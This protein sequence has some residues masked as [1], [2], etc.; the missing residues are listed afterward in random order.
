MKA[1]NGW[2]RNEPAAANRHVRDRF[3][4]Y[5]VTLKRLPILSCVASLL[6]FAL[7]LEAQSNVVIS[8]IYGGGGNSG[9]TLRNDFVELFN[10][11][12][13][14]ANIAG[15]SVQYASASGSNWDRAVLSGAVQ[16]GQYYLVQL[17]QGTGGSAGLPAPD[18]T[19]GLNLSAT[20][21]KVA[22]V[23]NSTLLT[24]T[25]P[26]GSQVVD[27]VGY[28]EANFA[29][30]GRS[31]P[32]LSN[33]TAG[34]RRSGGCTDSNNNQADF[35][36]GQPAPRNTRSPLAPCF[37]TT[38][39]QI[40]AA[41]VTNGATFRSGPVAPGEIITLFGSGLGP[42][43]ISTLQLTSDRLFVTKSLAGTRV[44]FDGA[45]AA[46][47]YTAAAQVSAITPYSLSGQ[48]STDLQVEYEG[49]LSN[50]VTLQVAPSAPGV[51][52]LDSSGI[53]QGAILNQ[54]NQV[55]GTS[56][57]AAKGSVV[58]IYATGGGQ[59]NP[60]GEDG[61]I[62]T[63]AARQVQNVFVR[64]G[65]ADATVEYAGAAPGLV[66]GIL[67]V[68][69]RIPESLIGGN[70]PVQITVG[71]V[72]SQTGVFVAVAGVGQQDGTSLLIEERF[73]RL[74]RERLTAALPEIPTDRDPIPAG[75]LAI[76]SWNTQVGGTATA[77]GSLRPP[78]VKSALAEMFGG[79][80][81]VLAAQE[82]PNNESAAL[83]RNLLPGGES[84]WRSAF[85]DTTDSMDNGFWYRTS[86]VLRDSFVLLTTDQQDSMGRFIADD[87]RALH[88]P[89]VAQF[90][91]G[92]FDFTLI[93]VHLT[94]ADGDTSESAR[95]MKEVLNY[96]DWYFNQ[97]DHDPDVV[98]CGDFNTPS[99]LSGQLGRDGITLDEVFDRDGRFQVG[100]RRFAV[101][102]HDSTSRSPASSGGGP[103]RNYDHC[104]V[105]ADT[106]EEFVQARRVS[107]NILTDHPDD[108]EVR[109]TSDHFPIVAFFK[110]AGDGVSLDLKKRIRPE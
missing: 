9:A 22:L 21:G 10:R 100:E 32:E 78:M 17:A 47:I 86:A 103:A 66:S 52:T 76:I 93:T 16:P 24:G 82:I 64:I 99:M 31:A 69:A 94:F 102:V 71:G 83:L 53:G 39:P 26:S 87:S 18:A 101:T 28:G 35:A 98:V 62:T 90:E 5:E 4:R 8:Q 104:V 97:P 63:A 107:T 38:A 85:F 89:Q 29:E 80:Y 60:A 58:I 67:Q 36:T 95:E 79:S 27:F 6:S 106:M 55:N 73:A 2:L 61:R 7:A 51:F 11:G 23:N 49:R 59:T 72:N 14:P 74:K 42:L 54:D 40:S 70:Q 1:P 46:M 68:N 108:P 56:N 33:T 43:N 37:A 91:I 34:F 45:P 57:P 19:A 84:A 75:W 25:S 109:L 105:S 3:R 41:G 92:D 88:P 30:G 96:L 44:L 50:R 15:W 20:S 77:S 65:D 48:T 81:Q 110:T 13:V 12:S